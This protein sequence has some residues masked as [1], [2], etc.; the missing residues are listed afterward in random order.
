MGTDACATGATLVV[1]LDLVVFLVVNLALLEALT[2]LLTERGREW[3]C[4]TDGPSSSEIE[5]KLVDI[6][7]DTTREREREAIS[8]CTHY[9]VNIHLLYGAKGPALGPVSG[10]KVFCCIWWF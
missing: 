5:A 9:T 8:V 1:V 3:D 7:T 4:G 10:V 6:D 2:G